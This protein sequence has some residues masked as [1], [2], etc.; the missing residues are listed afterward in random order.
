M[1]TFGWAG[2]PCSNCDGRGTHR[3][4][5]FHAWKSRRLVRCKNC[6]GHGSI[7]EYAPLTDLF[8]L[9]QGKQR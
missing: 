2:R 5:G 3:K 7:P 6:R 1:T 9:E 8:Q 4:I